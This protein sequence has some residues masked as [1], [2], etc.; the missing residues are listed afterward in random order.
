M[1]INSLVTFVYTIL[2]S[3]PY[4]KRLHSH[5]FLYSRFFGNSF[6]SRSQIL[7]LVSA[8]QV[9]GQKFCFH[10]SCTLLGFLEPDLSQLTPR[11]PDAS[12]GRKDGDTPCSRVT[13][14]R[15]CYILSEWPQVL[16]LGR[17]QNLEQSV[18]NTVIPT[19][20][21]S[22]SGFQLRLISDPSMIPK[23]T[24]LWGKKH[25]PYL[26]FIVYMSAPLHIKQNCMTFLALNVLSNCSL[27]ISVYVSKLS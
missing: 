10:E 3:V 6:Y 5:S 12:G 24:V 11:F 27:L 1:E 21:R 16:F 2:S 14:D 15:S 22:S 20:G 9:T 18:I 8:L 4:L 13:K 17:D 25:E 26:E 23:E 7:S 19:Y